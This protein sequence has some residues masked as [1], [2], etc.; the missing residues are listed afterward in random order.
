M[1]IENIIGKILSDA[2]KEAKELLD[3][4]GREKEARLEKARR[5]SLNIQKE[6]EAK[7]LLDAQLHKE[8]RVSVAELESR[9]LALAAKQEAITMSFDKALEA[10]SK[11][12]PDRYV[13]LLTDAVLATGMS[14]GELL[15]NKT[16]REAIGQKV[17]DAVNQTGKVRVTLSRETISAKGGFVLR[18]GDV[19]V[20]ATLETMLNGVKESV[21]P[22]VVK[23]L[24]D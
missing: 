4:A 23:I 13:R 18:K 12:E 11:M 9:K 20:N 10:L 17:A 2:E 14:E 24:F 22:S 16:D 8:R 7:A 3:G 21:T 19:T 15:F 1:S 5:E 6:A